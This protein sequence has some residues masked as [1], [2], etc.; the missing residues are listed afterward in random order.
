VSKSFACVLN[1]FQLLTRCGGKAEGGTSDA[2]AQSYASELMKRIATR[3]VRAPLCR[4]I[5]LKLV[6]YSFV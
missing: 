2:D 4:G 3:C 6:D 1:S 5:F